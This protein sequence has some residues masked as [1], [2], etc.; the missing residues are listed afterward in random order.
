[1]TR[2]RSL[3]FV[4]MALLATLAALSCGGGG[5]GYGGPTAPPPMQSPPPSGSAHVVTIN[6][7]SYDPKSLTIQPGE[8]VRWVLNGGQTNHTVT[9]KDGSFDSGSI[10]TSKGAI[11]EH[12][13]DSKG[14]FEY[15][16]KVHGNCCG[17]RGSVLVGS[18]APPPD[19]SYQ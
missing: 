12:R 8:T 1:M 19:P 17:M 7:D 3:C 18:D 15:A 11:Y 13:F 2:I 9:A 6:D 5:G 10:F 14:T 16:C 4:L